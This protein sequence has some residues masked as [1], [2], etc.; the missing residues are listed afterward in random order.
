VQDAPIQFDL[1]LTHS[2]T[3]PGKLE[4]RLEMHGVI[5]HLRTRKPTEDEIERYQVGQ[6]QAVELTED[7]PWEPYSTKFAE[8]ELAACAAHSVTVPRVTSPRSKDTCIT[9]SEAEEGFHP[10]RLLI[11]TERCISV[12]T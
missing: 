12:A 5:S 11:L 4:I 2:I 9:S 6:L 8:T 7:S 10:R 3:I 1:K